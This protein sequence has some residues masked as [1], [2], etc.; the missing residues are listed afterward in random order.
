MGPTDTIDSRWPGLLR[1]N[2]L[3]SSPTC[4]L[5][6]SKFEVFRAVFA[7]LCRGVAILAA[8]IG[9]LLWNATESRAA[10]CH[11]PDRP[12]LR[13]GLSWQ[14][15]MSPDLNAAPPA[16]APPILTHPPCEGE[17]PRVLERV[18]EAP[19]ADGCQQ[20]GDDLPGA[21]TA[22]VC[23]SPAHPPQPP[24]SRLDRPPRFIEP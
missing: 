1:S 20:I 11:V 16:L 3:L 4:V 12:V 10:G 17:S 21:S 24:G 15:N 2:E 22:V 19:A 23:R 5:N 7:H 9:G 8:A 18:G 14:K 6:R 13:G